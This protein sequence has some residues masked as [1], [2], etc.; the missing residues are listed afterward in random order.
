ME[1]LAIAPDEDGY[2]FVEPGSFL[3]QELEGGLP[4]TRADLINASKT[5]GVQW[6]VGVADYQYLCNFNSA[7]LSND[8]EPFL[9]PLFIDEVEAK[10]Y[11]AIILPGTFGLVSQSGE[12]YVVGAQLEVTVT[13]ATDDEYTDGTTSNAGTGVTGAGYYAGST[14]IASGAGVQPLFG[15]YHLNGKNAILRRQNKII[16]PIKGSYVLNGQSIILTRDR[17]IVATKGSYALNGQAA[18]IHKNIQA[19]TAA[20]GSYALNGQAAALTYNGPTDPNFANV[21]LL[22]HFNGSNNGTVFT[23]SSS[24]N[25]TVNRS[26]TGIVTNTAQIKFGSASGSFAGNANPSFLSIATTTALN[27]S[28]GDWTIE[29]WIR[30][31]STS[32][33]QQIISKQ[34]GTGAYPFAIYLNSHGAGKL[35]FLCFDDAGSANLVIDIQGAS[36]LSVGT[37]YH[38]AFTRNGNTFTG[39]LSGVS[40]GTGTSSATLRN[41]FP[42]SVLIG[43][44]GT[45]AASPTG[46]PYEGYIDDVRITKGVARYTASFTPPAAQFPDS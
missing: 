31:A 27:L 26:G 35:R 41:Q 29:A 2:T 22:L 5:V 39:W 10:D 19:L 24:N 30:P 3:Y 14:E 40:E 4:R 9:I 43:C 12:T 34:A 6:T 18:N 16:N 32:Y 15:S 46:S 36:V 20:Y 23:D 45:A 13:P 42:E 38:V 17:K 21:S 11:E 28:L 1:T 33:A 8:S 44:T 37:W 7:N 25:H